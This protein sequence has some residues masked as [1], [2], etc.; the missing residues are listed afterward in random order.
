MPRGYVNK[1]PGVK[2]N[3]ALAAQYIRERMRKKIVSNQ[4]PKDTS[5]ILYGMKTTK[6]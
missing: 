6:R 3:P 5:R 1:F 2:Q 4:H